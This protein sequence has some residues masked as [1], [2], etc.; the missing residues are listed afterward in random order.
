MVMNDRPQPVE[1]RVFIRGN[2]GRPGEAVP[3][4]FL[5]VLSDPERAPFVDGSGRLD[6]A[7]AVA[8]PDNPLTARVMVNRVWMHHFGEGLVRTPGDFGLRGEPPSH[9]ELLDYLAARFVEGGWSVKALHRLILTSNAYRQASDARPESAER[10]PQNAL[11][12]R[13]A[14]RRLDFE[15]MRDSLLAAA[16][17]LDGRM[18]GRPV[19]LTAEPS[20][21]RRT[22]YG[23][24]DRQNLDG[25]FRTFDFAS[26]DASAPRRSETTVP[27]QALFL[28]NSPFAAEQARHLAS[29]LDAIPADRP[30]ARVRHLYRL[31]FG[32]DAEPREVEAGR[33]FVE[34]RVGPTQG[35]ALGPWPAYAQVLMLTNEFLYVD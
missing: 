15:A 32:R 22:L 30:E 27:Q 14:R 13:Q 3:R 21:T 33:A 6:L 2:P 35:D 12:S 24:I 16:G 5:K 26:P 18:G 34:S 19:M 10:D 28:M 8:N 4:R 11:L 29:R 9:P 17:R 25:L 23:F 31:L 20:P 1:P 7:R